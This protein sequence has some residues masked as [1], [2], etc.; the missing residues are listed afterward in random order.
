MAFYISPLPNVFW[1]EPDLFLKDRF[2]SVVAGIRNVS[3]VS[4]MLVFGLS[5]PG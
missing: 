3:G 4:I 5:A 2:N 1:P